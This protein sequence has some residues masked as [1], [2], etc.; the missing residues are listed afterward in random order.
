MRFQQ[1]RHKH[2]GQRMKWCFTELKSLLIRNTVLS[3]RYLNHRRNT[4]LR[5]N[6]G[7]G[8]FSKLQISELMR[9]RTRV[10]LAMFWSC[11]SSSKSSP[12]SSAIGIYLWVVFSSKGNV[13]SLLREGCRLRKYKYRDQWEGNESLVESTRKRLHFVIGLRGIS[14]INHSNP[15]YL[16]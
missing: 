9:L 12:S 1:T 15:F 13:K 16:L 8:T 10:L 2:K 6:K 7:F 3:N 5:R 4:R 14:L 11:L